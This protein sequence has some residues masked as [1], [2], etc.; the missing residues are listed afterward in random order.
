MRPVEIVFAL[1]RPELIRPE[2]IRPVEMVFALKLE[3]YSVLKVLTRG[4]LGLYA[5]PLIDDTVKELVAK[6]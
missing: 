5:K 1:M 4:G 3:V 2:L 6:F